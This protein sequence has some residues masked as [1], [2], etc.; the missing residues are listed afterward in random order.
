LTAGSVEIVAF[1]G[2]NGSFALPDLAPDTNFSIQVFSAGFDPVQVT[3]NSNDQASLTIRFAETVATLRGMVIYS[4][5]TPIAG[6]SVSAGKLGTVQ[7]N[8]AGEFTFTLPVR[9]QYTLSASAPEMFFS[10]EVSGVLLGDT[11]R[12]LVGI[13]D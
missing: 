5:G 1:S 11:V 9:S 4:D 6:A 13:D 10:R 12:T 3:G 2:S 7:T 8:A